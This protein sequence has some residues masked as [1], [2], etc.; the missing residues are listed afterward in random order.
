MS[1]LR[2]SN[3]SSSSVRKAPAIAVLTAVGCLAACAIDSGDFSPGEDPGI[4]VTLVPVSA[5]GGAGAASLGSN[6]AMQQ[7]GFA[8]AVAARAGRVYVVDSMAGGLVQTDV[9]GSEIRLIRELRDGNTAGLYVTSDLIIFVVDR[10][11]RVVLEISDTG[12]ERRRYADSRLIPVPVD[13]TQINW[14]STIVIADELSKRLV[15]FDNL[16]NPTG[17][18]NS[19]LSPVMSVASIGAVAANNGSVFVLDRDS[20]EA[21]QLDLQ[22]L[23]LIHI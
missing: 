19:T 18:M 11:S 14:G 5:I 13:V 7:L 9:F 2:K 4:D 10:Q 23:S 21:T 6:G 22:G 16:S 8:A 1:S 12:W 17:M 20:R 15:L 3:Q